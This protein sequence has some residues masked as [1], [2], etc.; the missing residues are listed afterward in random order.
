LYPTQNAVKTYVDSQV[1]SGN[2]DATSSV[3]GK[4]QLAGDLDGTA[5]LP[6]IKTSAITTAKLAADAVT[7]A[8]IA[9]GEIVNADIST[10]AAIADSKLATIATANKVS[11]SATTATNAN[12]ASAIVAR[13][14]SG[15]FS[16]GTITATGFSGPL[17]GNASTATKLAAT[18][19]INGTA[20]DGSSDITVIADAGTLSGTSLKSTVVSSS[21]TSVGTLTNLTVTNPIAGSVTGTAA[22]VTGTVAV[23]NGGTGATT[24]AA[25]LTNLGAAPIASPTF[26]G[27]VTAPIYAST[28]QVLTDDATI[29]WNPL[30]GLNASVT[31]GGNRTLS[32]SSTPA[33]GAYGTLVVTQ[34]AT[35]S[36]T[37][38]L[39][40]TA[41]IN[42]VLGSTSTT[43]ITLSTAANAKDIL[44]FYYDGTNCFWNIGQ[45]YGTA[46]ASSTTNLATSVT[47]T[48]AVAN[49]GTGA[50]TLTGYVKGTGTTAMTASAAIPVADVTGAAPLASP[51]FTGTPSLPTGTTGVTQT[52]GNNTTALATTQFVTSAV[53]SAV[54]LN[55]DEF[56]ATA[57]QTVFNA[58]NGS[59]Q[60]TQ[61][62]LNNKVFMFINGT[63]IKNS[64]YTVS[65]TTVT[66]IPANNNSYALVVG[67]RI[68]FDYAY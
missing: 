41:G 16:A 53:A 67:D 66:Y 32:F 24:A 7:S 45:G 36:R 35:G 27:S 64:A 46:A 34:D 50:A 18:K 3:K 51:E 37:I 30:N 39:P 38:T 48:L 14:A 21:L 5:A 31:L 58:T 57:S 1:A 26:T 10:S 17:S 54:R 12:T 19:N 11:N 40:S 43:T 20:F 23:L 29:A 44:N 33:A 8:K 61:T 4:L 52:A 59:S 47:G 42:K 2:P 9:D 60:L 13:D 49:G 63:R 55:S 68:Q 56:T 65:G 62:P 15:D 22:N 6:S 25:A 28:P